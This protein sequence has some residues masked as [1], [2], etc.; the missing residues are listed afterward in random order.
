MIDWRI[1]EE[2]PDYA[3]ND[4]GEVLNIKRNRTL[5]SRMNRQDFMMIGLVRDRMQYTRATAPLVANAFLE[6]AA[7]P[8]YNSIIHLNGD[9]TDCRAINLMWRPRW[10]ASRYH[11]MFDDYP[12]RVSVYIPELDKV[13]FSLRE[14]CTT[15]GLVESYSYATMLDGQPCFHYGWHIERAEL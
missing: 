4:Q 10:Y 12:L 5:A 15:Y 6:P 7:S 8:A 14:F 11:R 9:R 1:I 3:V 2:F 13:F